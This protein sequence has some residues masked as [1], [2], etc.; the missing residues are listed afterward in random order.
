[1]ITNFYKFLFAALLAVIL[2]FVLTLRAKLPV[3]N[4]YLFIGCCLLS[5]LCFSGKP[6]DK[7]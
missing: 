1:M 7:K 6:T 3:D 4:N 2:F 5:G